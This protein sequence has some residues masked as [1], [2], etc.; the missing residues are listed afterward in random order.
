[1]NC[2]CGPEESLGADAEAKLSSEGGTAFG[3]VEYKHWLYSRT[4][5]QEAHGVPPG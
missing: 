5:I 2:Q 4:R 3:E 1:M